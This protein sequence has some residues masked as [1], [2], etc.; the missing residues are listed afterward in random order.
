MGL[1]FSELRSNPQF[2]HD[3]LVARL[4]GPTLQA[5]YP[6]FTTPRS[7]INLRNLMLRSGETAEVPD[8]PQ[9]DFLAEDKKVASVSWREY[10]RAADRMR[11]L[12]S[13]A[14]SSQDKATVTYPDTGRDIGIILLSDLHW[15]S[16]GSDHGLIERI[17]DEIL[18]IP[19]LYCI[20]LGDLEHM[21]IKLRGVLEVTDNVLTPRM[22]HAYTESWLKEIGHRIVCSTW[23]NHSVMREENQAGTSIYAQIMGR[24]VV[25]H[26]GIGHVDIVVG[27]ERYRWAVSHHFRGRS[28]LNPVHAQMR[29]MRMEG[30]DREIAAAGDSHVP[31]IAMYTDGTRKR[32]AINSGTAQTNSGYAKRFFS[33]V[34]HPVFPV[35]S[36]SPKGHDFT[37]YWSVGEWLRATGRAG[38]TT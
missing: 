37:A 34:S 11:R 4:P 9:P 5:K 17:T 29:Y 25:Y 27:K 15:G 12:S 32:L 10:G 20:A 31:G 23:C 8:A 26:N 24:H 36:L 2:R 13:K 38:A 7:Y 18:G 30:L 1:T 16:Y 3:A 19:D 14:S 33:L 21:A 35:V 6:G 22:Q 28:M